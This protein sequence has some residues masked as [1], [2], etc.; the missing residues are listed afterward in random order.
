MLSRRLL[1][2]IR[3]NLLSTHTLPN[4]NVHSSFFIK[5][6]QS[7]C[8]VSLYHSGIGA[9]CCLVSLLTNWIAVMTGYRA[10]GSLENGTNRRY[11][12]SLSEVLVTQHII[13]YTVYWVYLNAISCYKQMFVVSVVVILIKMAQN[14]R[15][16]HGTYRPSK[17]EM[18][19]SRLEF[20]NALKLPP[21]ERLI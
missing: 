9:V 11:A 2:Q 6:L 17:Q 1:C 18:A 5:Y 4:V 20:G 3:S 15:A 13:K 21:E 16:Q 10:S 19:G 7:V 12:P 14:R 8:L